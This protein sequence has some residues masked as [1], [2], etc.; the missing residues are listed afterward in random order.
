L[1]PFL[2]AAPGVITVGNMAEKV[3]GVSMDSVSLST[4]GS[5]VALRMQY[6]VAQVMT[7]HAGAPENDV[8]RILTQR[9]RG[10][11]I[12]PNVREI[13]QIAKT[14]AGLPKS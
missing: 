9:L 1:L 3:S 11:G 13:Q 5:N 12:S 6:V 7:S 10:M 14:I 8:L 2:V 4:Y